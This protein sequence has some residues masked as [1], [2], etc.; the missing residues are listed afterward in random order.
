MVQIRDR[1]GLHLGQLDGV[2]EGLFRTWSRQARRAGNRRATDFG[3]QILAQDRLAD[4]AEGPGRARRNHQGGRRRIAARL[5][6]I[7]DLS[8]VFERQLGHP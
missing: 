5:C 6:A 1:T 7:P 3:R 8:H 2:P 4:F